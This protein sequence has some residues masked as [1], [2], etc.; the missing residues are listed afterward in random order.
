M[1]RGGC[2]CGAGIGASDRLDDLVVLLA[3]SLDPSFVLKCRRAWKHKSVVQRP[4]RFQQ[5]SV[6][7]GKVDTSVEILID[8]GCSARIFLCCENLCVQVRHRVNL[9]CT[10]MF[11]SNLRS[12]AFQHHAHFVQFNDLGLRE[13][14]NDGTDSGAVL[15]DLVALQLVYRFPDGCAGQRQTFCH[16]YFAQSVTWLIRARPDGGM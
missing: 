1:T 3:D 5:E 15:N 7:R 2:P 8:S 10:R 14:T 13:G 4:R 12:R 11:G 16:I 6:S 9:C